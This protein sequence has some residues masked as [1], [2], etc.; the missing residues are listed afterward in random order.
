[1]VSHTEEVKETLLDFASSELTS[2]A[3]SLI[4]LSILLFT[5]LTGILTSN[6][7]PRMQFA[8]P[9]SLSDFTKSTIDYGFI[10]CIFWLLDTGIVFTVMRLM[11]YGSFAHEIVDYDKPVESL[12]DLRDILDKEMT[13]KR[14]WIPNIFWFKGGMGLRRRGF[15][16]SLFIGFVLT[17]LLFY[18]FFVK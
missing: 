9:Q 13:T 10:F 15:W 1:L 6:Y 14:N 17:S 5:F 3:N 16:F 11:F 12:H 4:G 8:L 7:F 2:H 18:I